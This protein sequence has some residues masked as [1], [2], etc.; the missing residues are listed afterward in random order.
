MG[1]S[2]EKIVVGYIEPIEAS[3]IRLRELQ[4][5]PETPTAKRKVEEI[6]VPTL[7][8]SDPVEVTQETMSRAMDSARFVSEHLSE[9]PLTPLTGDVIAMAFALL[10]YENQ[11]KGRIK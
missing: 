4:T 10:H 7:I 1:D 8:S 3:K 11:V 6:F 9:L 5:Q 2:D